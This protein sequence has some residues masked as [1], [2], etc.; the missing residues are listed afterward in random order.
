[1]AD[2]LFASPSHLT[3]NDNQS[4]ETFS[5]LQ[6]AAHSTMQHPRLCQDATVTQSILHRNWE[7]SNKKFQ[8]Q[9]PV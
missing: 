7:S 2:S 6:T 9:L 3:F 8:H 5:V 1:M 4:A